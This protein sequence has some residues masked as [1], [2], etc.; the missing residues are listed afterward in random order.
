MN[1]KQISIAEYENVVVRMAKD[2]TNDFV[3]N[4]TIQH[5]KILVH[6]LVNSAEDTIK[7]Y[8][9]EFYDKFYLDEKIMEAF[10]KAYNN[11]IK[12]FLISKKD[13]TENNAF[14]KYADIFNSN[15]KHCNHSEDITI[16]ISD[17]KHVLNNFMVIDDNGIRYEQEKKTSTYD[18]I[19]AKATFNSP[20]D[21]KPFVDAFDA[22]FP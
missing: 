17:N 7:I 19:Q 22:I 12:L 1:I 4:D 15:F 13:I 11:D 2:K 21:V 6:H 18:N 14:I 20:N 8:T 9:N 10:N 5:A 3:D 16:M